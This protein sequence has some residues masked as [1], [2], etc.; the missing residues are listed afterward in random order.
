MSDLFKHLNIKVDKRQQEM[1][2][3]KP[4]KLPKISFKKTEIKPHER[5]PFVFF[6]DNKSEIELMNK[7]FK[8]NNMCQVSN[9]NLL[10]ELLKKFED[11]KK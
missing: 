5:Q 6:F 4:D 9:T 2:S 11:Y 1:I 8:T 3:L 7:Y 10:I